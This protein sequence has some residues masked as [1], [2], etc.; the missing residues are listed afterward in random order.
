MS[1]GDKH[2]GDAD[3]VGGDA[4]GAMVTSS[5]SVSLKRDEEKGRKQVKDKFLDAV[6]ITEVVLTTAANNPEIWASSD[7][8]TVRHLAYMITGDPRKW[9]SS[10]TREGWG[11]TVED[12]TKG[13]GKGMYERTLSTNDLE[14]T[15]LVLQIIQT[16][17]T[18]VASDIG[19]TCLS[20]KK[21]K[22]AALDGDGVPIILRVDSTRQSRPAKR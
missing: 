4:D 21:W 15:P 17:E 12:L 13:V 8:A 19:S 7:M 16:E 3:G 18:S 5:V 9:P 20:T 1:A 14:G 6:G 11:E 2:G 22:L 10:R